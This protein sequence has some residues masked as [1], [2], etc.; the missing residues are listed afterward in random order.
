MRTSA[1]FKKNMQNTHMLQS[2]KVLYLCFLFVIIKLINLASLLFSSFFRHLYFYINNKTVQTSRKCR[3]T[4]LQTSKNIYTRTIIFSN[5]FFPNFPFSP[6]QWKV[7]SRV[8]AYTS[9]T[10]DLYKRLTLSRMLAHCRLIV[11]AITSSVR[12]VHVWSKAEGL[13]SSDKIPHVITTPYILSGYRPPEQPWKYYLYSIFSVSLFYYLFC[14]GFFIFFNC[15]SNYINWF[16]Y[17]I[18]DEENAILF[19]SRVTAHVTTELMEE[20]D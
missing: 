10:V 5:N 9:E 2:L 17:K 12:Y 14:L 1:V 7:V 3:L 4:W 15:K 11:S 6:K 16:G 8:A 18:Q 20:D 13:L 19:F